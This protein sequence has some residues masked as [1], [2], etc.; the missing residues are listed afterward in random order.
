M[1]DRKKAVEI[2]CIE[3]ISNESVHITNAVRVLAL[4]SL[5][6]SIILFAFLSEMTFA[7]YLCS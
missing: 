2:K 5:Y 7:K 3:T 6:T 1:L 4:T